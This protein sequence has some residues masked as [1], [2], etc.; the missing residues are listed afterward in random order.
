MGVGPALQPRSPLAF[1][2]GGWAT[3]P[4]L[5]TV[6]HIPPRPHSRTETGCPPT[7]P[8]TLSPAATQREDVCWEQEEHWDGCSPRGVP[9]PLTPHHGSS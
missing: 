6:P 7:A 9:R 1:L 8:E 3:F 2:S 5:E 4:T